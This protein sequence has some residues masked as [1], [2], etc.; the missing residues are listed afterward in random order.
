MSQRESTEPARMTSERPA[1]RLTGLRRASLAALV[2]LTVQYGLGMY[3]NLYVTVPG[4]DHGKDIGTAISNGPTALSAHAVLGLLL[5]LTAIGVLVQA[6]IARLWAVLA[7]AA[8]ALIAIIGAAAE[9]VRFA[10]QGPADASMTMAMLTGVALLGYG[11]AL[12][13]L[14]S[15]RPH[16]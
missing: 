1:R 16:R 12:Y 14:S 3:V 13:L 6:L 2:I 11:A 5:V 9:G 8:V 4:A 7:P 10:S 15:P